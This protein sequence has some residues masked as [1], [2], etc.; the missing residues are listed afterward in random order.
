[1]SL[2][3]FGEL[4]PYEVWISLALALGPFL[5]LAVVVAVRRRQA[6]A[7]EDAAPPGTADVMSS[8]RHDDPPS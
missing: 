3:H 8:G 1:M 7:E 6:I 5:V 4:H 2:L